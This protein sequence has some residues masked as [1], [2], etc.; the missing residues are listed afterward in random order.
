MQRVL[1]RGEKADDRNANGDRTH[2]TCPATGEPNRGDGYDR[3]SG[4]REIEHVKVILT[5]EAVL[6]SAEKCEY[7]RGTETDVRFEED[8]DDRDG[9]EG[10]ETEREA[11]TNPVIPSE[12]TSNPEPATRH[13]KRAN[14]MPPRARHARNACACECKACEYDMRNSQRKRSEDQRKEPRCERHRRAQPRHASVVR[15]TCDVPEE[16]ECGRTSAV[17]REREFGHGGKACRYSKSERRRDEA[18]RNE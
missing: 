2:P 14:I 17:D 13:P 15:R 11:R 18:S 7:K 16:K 9:D 10:D 3:A 1:R 5:D 8:I 6:E 4:R 12:S